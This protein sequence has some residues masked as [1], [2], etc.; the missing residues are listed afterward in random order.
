M[1]RSLMVFSLAVMAISASVLILAPTLMGFV[2]AQVAQGVS[3]GIFHTAAQTHS[4]RI[5]GIPSRRLAYVHTMGQLGRFVG[6]GLAGTI[7]IFSLDASLWAAVG[8]AIGGLVVGFSLDPMPLYVR[9]PAGVRVPI[10]KRS[11]LGRGCWGGAIA[12][13]WRGVGES[14]I[15]VVLSEAGLAASA[16]GWMMSGADGASFLT[17]ASVAKWGG[18]DIGRFVPLGAAGLATS[19]LLLP[20]VSALVPIAFLM[21]LAGG[22]GGVAGVLGTTAANAVV[23]PSEQG[24]AIALVGTYRSTTRFASPALVSGAL[25]IV[26]L[27]VALAVVAVGILAPVAWFRPSTRQ[28]SATG[29]DLGGR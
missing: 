20:V 4:V 9:A 14:F 11:G 28:S 12:G 25:S 19:L 3:R 22:S 27:P 23:E 17:T 15:P 13:A 21:I 10:W 24:A 16:I 8:L 5:P 18:A 7:A 1:D 6:P 29:P 2:V 26:A